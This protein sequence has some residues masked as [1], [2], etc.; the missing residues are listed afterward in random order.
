M[1]WWGNEKQ[2]LQPP[3]P[4]FCRCSSPV[5]RHHQPEEWKKFHRQLNKCRPPDRPCESLCQ[6]DLFIKFTVGPSITLPYFASAGADT[7]IQARHPKSWEGRRCLAVISRT[8]WLLRGLVDHKGEPGDLGRPS[9][10]L[11]G[12]CHCGSFPGRIQLAS[13]LSNSSSAAGRFSLP[14]AQAPED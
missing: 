2:G 1:G 10:E 13:H 7:Q 9:W 3:T 5:L 4:T 12:A 8:L 11:G 6:A 14:V